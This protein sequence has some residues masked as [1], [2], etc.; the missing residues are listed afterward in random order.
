M[1]TQNLWPDFPTEEIKGPKAILKEQAIYLSAKTNKILSAD[2]VTTQYKDSMIH[3][4]YVVAPALGNYRYKLFSLEH[5]ALYYPSHL[6]WSRVGVEPGELGEDFIPRE[7][8]N[9]EEL[10]KY[11]QAVFYDSSTKKIISSLLSQSLAEQA[12]QLF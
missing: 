5:G 1:E 3:S 10:V 4:F 11:L 6:T 2:V 8:N 7:I 9:E 12:D